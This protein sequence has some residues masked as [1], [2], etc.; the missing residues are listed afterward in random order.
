MNAPSTYFFVPA[1]QA[2]S[3]VSSNPATAAAVISVLISCTTSLM[4][5]AALARQEW[6]NPAE[7]RAPVTSAISC[8]QRSTGTCW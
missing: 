8:W 6:M 4:I 7:T 3:V 1:G 5:S 2:R